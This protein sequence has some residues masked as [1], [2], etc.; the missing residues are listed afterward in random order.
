[1]IMGTQLTI[2]VLVGNWDGI[3]GPDPIFSILNF[4]EV[5]NCFFTILSRFLCFCHWNFFYSI[6]SLYMDTYVAHSYKQKVR[7]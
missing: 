2:D 1:M 5:F 3:P 7:I 4:P 6:S